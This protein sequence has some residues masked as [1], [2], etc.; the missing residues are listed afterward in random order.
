MRP[1]PF[2]PTSAGLTALALVALALLGGCEIVPKVSP[3]RNVV[4]GPPSAS[5]GL[6]MH[7]VH[8]VGELAP[9]LLRPAAA[10]YRLGPGDQIDIEIV[11]NA[12]AFAAEYPPT[13][14]ATVTVGPDGDIYYYTLPAIDVW[15]LT[16]DEAQERIADAMR[17]YVRETPMVSVSLRT[18]ASERVWVLGEVAHAGIYTLD[19]PTTLLDAIAEAGGLSSGSPLAS[20]ASSLGLSGAP[21]GGAE[22]ADL[23]R[24]F[25]VR[26]GRILP[27]D[28]QRLLRD[29]DL[30]QNIYL[31]PGDFVFIPPARS[32]QI[33]ILGA[34]AVPRAEKLSGRLTLVQAV[35]LAGGTVPHAYLS[36]VAI[37]RGSLSHPQIGLVDLGAILHGR[38][39]DVAL[40]PGDIVY[41]PFS[42]YRTLDRYAMLIVDTFART[43][44]VNEG[45]R[46][47]SSSAS[48]V[49]VSVSVTP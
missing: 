14:V 16:L 30:S 40:E 46:A 3:G 5:A 25:V 21:A 8:P 7:A 41:V 31:H 9:A 26:Q 23:S 29:G 20:L 1:P 44:G 11:G 35:A 12:A 19:G 27:V 45:A 33:H 37:L 28:F 4:K 6:G 38:A 24:A 36:D 39:A 2:R 43:L 32:R 47:I 42:P 15:G 13:G 17:R 34:V 49:G 10:P 22:T 48:G 18:A